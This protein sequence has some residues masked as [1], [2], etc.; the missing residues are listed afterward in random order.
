M[1][2]MLSNCKHAT[3]SD[4]NNNNNN[5]RF[6]RRTNDQINTCFRKA[7]INYVRIFNAQC[8]RIPGSE[9]TLSTVSLL[10]YSLKIEATDTNFN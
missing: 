4:N 5:C 10:S 1:F 8:S 2:T 6:T 9:N 7:N 3:Q